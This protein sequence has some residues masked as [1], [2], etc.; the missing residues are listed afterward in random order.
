MDFFV[1]LQETKT[2]TFQLCFFF[3][4]FKPEIGSNATKGPQNSIATAIIDH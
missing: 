3:F 1:F 2:S 4:F